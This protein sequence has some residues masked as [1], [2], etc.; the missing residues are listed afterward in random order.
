MMVKSDRDSRLRGSD[1]IAC[2]TFEYLKSLPHYL[3]TYNARGDADIQRVDVAWHRDEQMVVE[4][5]H[6]GGADAVFF[7]THHHAKWPSQV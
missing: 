4:A 5:A 3:K 1:A 2:N 6:V 7:R